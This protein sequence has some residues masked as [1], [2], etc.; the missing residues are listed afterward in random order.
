MVIKR[1]PCADHVFG[2]RSSSLFKVLITLFLRNATSLEQC[3]DG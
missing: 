1:V 2:E 3:K